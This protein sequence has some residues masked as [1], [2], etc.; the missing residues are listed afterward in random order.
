MALT[1]KPLPIPFLLVLLF[2]MKENQP[3]S[4]WTVV[5]RI[6]CSNASPVKSKTSVR[7]RSLRIRYINIYASTETTK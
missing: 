2:W 5:S 6:Y 1:C 7:L 3:L 4:L